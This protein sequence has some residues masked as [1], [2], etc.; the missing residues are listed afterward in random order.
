M[1]KIKGLLLGVLILIIIIIIILLVVIDNNHNNEN[2]TEKQ[3]NNVN[4]NIVNIKEVTNP[5]MYITVKSCIEKYINYIYIDDNISVYRIIDN[6][7]INKFNLTENNILENVEDIANPVTLDI[8]KMY[9]VEESE[10]EQEYYVSSTIKEESVEGTIIQE[11]DFIVTVKLDISNM[12]YSIIPNG[13][14]GPLYE[15]KK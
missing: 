6:E 5:H 1:K 13:Y 3:D 15:E 12:T 10:N 4:E 11:K 14:G 2:Y 7:Y 8:E 9:I